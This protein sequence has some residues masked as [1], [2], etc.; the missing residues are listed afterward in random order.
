M[1]EFHKGTIAGIFIGVMFSL[2]VSIM[3]P[4]EMLITPWKINKLELLC[5]GNAV[6]TLRDAR[7]GPGADEP[8]T[9]EVFCGDGIKRTGKYEIVGD[10]K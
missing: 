5:D 7:I 10:M 8:Q 4:N 1:E 9:F 2:L 6:I 3:M